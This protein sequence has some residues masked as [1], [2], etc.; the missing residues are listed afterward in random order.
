[1]QTPTIDRAAMAGILMVK[2]V[3]NEGSFDYLDTAITTQEMNAFL[4]K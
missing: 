3:R 1:M 4:G 2:E